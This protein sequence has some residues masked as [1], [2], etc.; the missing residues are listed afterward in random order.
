MGV[1]RHVLAVMFDI[2]FSDP[3]IYNPDKR[4]PFKRARAR[5]GIERRSAKAGL[6]GPC[7]T[8]GFTSSTLCP[9]RV[10]AASVHG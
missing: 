6:W 9:E 5:T 2:L 7:P 10:R 3:D 8:I 4:Q 1:P